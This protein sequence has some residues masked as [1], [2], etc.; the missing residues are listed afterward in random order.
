LERGYFFNSGGRNISVIVKC[1]VCGEEVETT[2]FRSKTQKYCS[3]KCKH[4]AMIKYP[5]KKCLW[6]QQ[7]FQT[8]RKDVVFCCRE[9]N[10]K[11]RYEKEHSSLT[12]A[13][14]GKTFVCTNTEA[15]YKKFCSVK[16]SGQAHKKEEHE[17]YKT[18]ISCTCEVCKKIFDVWAYRG[19]GRKVRFCSRK[20]KHEA[21][22]ITINCKGCGQ[23]FITTKWEYNQNSPGKYCS[24]CRESFYKNSTSFFEEEVKEELSKKLTIDTRKVVEVNKKKKIYPDIT[25]GDVIVECQ[26]DYWHCNPKKFSADYI[27]LRYN[28]T[29]KE[30]WE[31]DEKRKEALLKKGFKVIFLWEDDWV[32]NKEETLNNLLKEIQGAI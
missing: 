17:R 6:C 5:A 18:T 3:R 7:E 11:H 4:I 24:F 21:G 8:Y 20:C 27:H 28:K 31:K 13:F 29:A 32:N 19:K 15:E 1:I 2:L 25:I 9:C 22:R 30:I 14:C 12:C 26:G 16:C 23:L 10:Q